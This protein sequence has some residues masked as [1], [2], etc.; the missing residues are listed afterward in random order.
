MTVTT[1]GVEKMALLNSCWVYPCSNPV[2]IQTR[3]ILNIS[4]DI[5]AIPTCLVSVDYFMAV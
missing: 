1:T 4:L 3:W 5:A 2:D